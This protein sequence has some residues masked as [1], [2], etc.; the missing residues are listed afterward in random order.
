M[1]DLHTETGVMVRFKGLTQMD[2]N[3]ADTDNML[4]KTA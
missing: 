2:D 3:K 4:L 1:I